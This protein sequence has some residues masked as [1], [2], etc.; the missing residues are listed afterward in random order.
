MAYNHEYPYT[1]PERY[2]SDW[3]LNKVK[4]VEAK[5]I[6]IEDEIFKRSKDY[7]DE[8]VAPYQAQVT[9][10]RA[11]FNRLRDEVARSQADFE[12]NIV[13]QITLMNGRID[14]IRRELEADIVSVNART[15]LAIQQNN[16]YIFDVIESGIIG[17]ISVINFFTGERVSVQDMFDYLARLH[18]DDG[19][20]YDDLVMRD[21]TYSEL[22]A[23]GISYTNLVLHG[24]T[25]I[26]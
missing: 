13:A 15:D 22:A 10:L 4:E 20:T 8:V 11:D 14:D 18:V 16:D 23:F 2:N 19:L 7:I 17:G 12:R 5:L 3:L 25:I 6:G 9:Q 21:K 26:I 24:G 1:D